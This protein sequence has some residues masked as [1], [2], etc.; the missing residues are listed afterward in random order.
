MSGDADNL[1][2]RDQERLRKLSDVRHEL[3]AACSFCAWREKTEDVG[4]LE[5]AL[6]ALMAHPDATAMPER[7]ADLAQ[8]GTDFLDSPRDFNARRDLD[9]GLAAYWRTKP[10]AYPPSRPLRTRQWWLND[11]PGGDEAA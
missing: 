8:A 3:M 11:G 1:A 10:A 6:A 2:I 5:A 7:L 4:R 9:R